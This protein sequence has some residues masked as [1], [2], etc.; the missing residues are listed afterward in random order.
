MSVDA[1]RQA[2]LEKESQA[3]RA[4]LKAWEYR[5]SSQNGGAKP[6]RDDIK[7]NP[8][9]AK[10]YKE[11][12]RLR[13]VLS[14]KVK[15]EP[16]SKR[17][18]PEP[19]QTPVKRARYKNIPETEAELPPPFPVMS[20][21]SVDRTAPSPAPPTS[22]G[23]TPHRDGKVL[24]L[25]AFLDENPHVTPSKT[26]SATDGFTVE[27]PSRA[28]QEDLDSFRLGRTPSSVSKRRYFDN[29]V[30]PLKPT[31]GNAQVLRTPTSVSKLQFGTPSFL[32][33]R[34]L[35]AVDEMPEYKSPEQ[36]RRTS[37]RPFARGL[38]AI[39]ANLR[40][41]EE[42]QF[43][44]DEEAMREM[45]TGGAPS[46]PSAPPALPAALPLVPDSQ[47]A[48]ASLPPTGLLGGF[49]DEAA[50]DGP[51][52]EDLDRGQPM[53]L[54]KKKGQKRTTRRVNMKPTFISR[55]A[56]EADP[57]DFGDGP[58]GEDDVVPET[59]V[60]DGPD[61]DFDGDYDDGG[62][63]GGAAPVS[64]GQKRKSPDEDKG[65]GGR[66]RK[67]AKKVNELAHANFR[68][69]K[70]RGAGAKGGGGFGSRFRKRR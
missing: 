67:V 21:P 66:V 34:T 6:S 16:S 25:F 13:D 50:F 28:E 29:M 41:V 35:P 51:I 26:T 11:Y 18:A 22:I 3:L 10:K 42:T 47:L 31:D 55:P 12:N 8:D 46:A 58:D 49:D 57:E 64:K 38:S 48:P 20:T 9:I 43:D 70:I 59:Q 7:R 27:T 24:G 15:D 5:W 1:T 32:R 36:L 53:R 62:E 14:G 4:D 39:V 52:E 37:R 56:A 2:A 54:F 17:K 44:D 68:R 65:E 30:T 61:G 63:A 60:V 40:K 69:L 19:V 33:R 45:E 23:P